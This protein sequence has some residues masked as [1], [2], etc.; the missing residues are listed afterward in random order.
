MTKD[1]LIVALGDVLAE[2]CRKEY[3]SDWVNEVRWKFATAVLAKL[4][5]LGCSEYDVLGLINGELSTCDGY[6]HESCG[7]D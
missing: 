4:D 1:E 7:M 2:E 6:C 3:G 5:D